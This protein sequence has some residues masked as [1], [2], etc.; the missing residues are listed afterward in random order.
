MRLLILAASVSLQI[1]QQVNLAGFD[2]TTAPG[3]ALKYFGTELTFDAAEAACQNN[4]PL[5]GH[6]ITVDNVAVS[7]WVM[8]KLNKMWIGL[9]VGVHF[10]GWLL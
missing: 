10:Q 3:R 7:N 6:L 1:F 5:P 2:L 4:M 9:K 8:N